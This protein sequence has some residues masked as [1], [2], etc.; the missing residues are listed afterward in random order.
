MFTILRIINVQIR[1]P[2]HN[3]LRRHG[4]PRPGHPPPSTCPWL[5]YSTWCITVNYRTARVVG[6]P[7]VV[8][9]ISPENVL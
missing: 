3:Y 7:L 8:I 5:L 6:V 4:Q 9:P 1:I 2:F